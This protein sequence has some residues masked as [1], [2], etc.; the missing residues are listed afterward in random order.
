MKTNK[1]K[2]TIIMSKIKNAGK[3]FVG[4]FGKQIVTSETLTTSA[5]IGILQ[6]LKYKGDF[7]RGIVAG[8]GSLVTQGVISGIVNVAQN[9]DSIKDCEDVKIGDGVFMFIKEVED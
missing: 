2:E 8:V 5:A 7:K 9:W 1:L 6:G 3:V 4:T